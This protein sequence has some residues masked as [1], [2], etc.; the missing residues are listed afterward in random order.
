MGF[1]GDSNSKESACNTEDL[2]LIPGLGRSLEKEIWEP[3]PLF[4]PGNPLDRGAWQGT[5]HGVAKSRKQL[6]DY[7]L[8]I[9]CNNLVSISCRYW[10][11]QIGYSQKRENL[12]TFDKMKNIEAVGPSIPWKIIKGTYTSSLKDRHCKH[13]AWSE[14]ILEYL[15]HVCPLINA[16]AAAAA[17]K[18]LQSCP[19]LCDPIDGSPPGSPV[20]GILQARTLEWVAISFS[21]AWKWKVTWSRSVMSDPQWSINNFKTQS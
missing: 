6:S 7:H 10:I 5:V 16:A 1:P 8:L 3:T 18:S 11:W 13:K 19:T 21:N 14:N 2:R 15:L 20:P 4:L 12:V 9:P 17:A